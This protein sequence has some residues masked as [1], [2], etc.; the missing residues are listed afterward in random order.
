LWEQVMVKQMLREPI[1]VEQMS[2]K[3]VMKEEA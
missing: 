1:I 3:Q 2:M